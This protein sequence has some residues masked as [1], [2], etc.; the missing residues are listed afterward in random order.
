M[1]SIALDRVIFIPLLSDRVQGAIPTSLYLLRVPL[2]SS[3]VVIVTKF[4]TAEKKV[5]SSVDMY[6]LTS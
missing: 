4:V 3:Y 5:Y 1:A 2:W 6:L